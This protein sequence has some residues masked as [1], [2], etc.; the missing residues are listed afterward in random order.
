MTKT[1]HVSSPARQ[2]YAV[3]QLARCGLLTTV[4]HQRVARGGIRTVYR[5]TSRGRDRF[6]ELL[7]AQFAAEGDLR[8]TLYGPM[9]FLHLT[10]LNLV[11]PGL[12]AAKSTG[13]MRGCRA[14]PETASA[15]GSDAA[16]R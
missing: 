14:D 3:R 15:M 4:A 16:Q 9:L 1:I 5:I 13:R 6:R 11:A 2:A 10:D 8:E 12:Y 7:H